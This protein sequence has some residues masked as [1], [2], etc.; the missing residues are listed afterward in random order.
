MADD[1]LLICH[2]Q[3]LCHGHIGW[4]TLKK[5]KPTTN[6][7]VRWQGDACG[8]ICTTFSGS[9]CKKITS[10]QTSEYIL[11][12]CNNNR[13]IVKTAWFM[14]CQRVDHYWPHDWVTLPPWNSGMNNIS[15]KIQVLLS[16]NVQVHKSVDTFENGNKAVLC[17]HNFHTNQATDKGSLNKSKTHGLLYSKFIML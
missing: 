14:C 6:A 15:L 2:D 4:K 8:T 1:L 12:Y 17:K 10:Y 9:W 13:G 7:H 16:E 11:F 5:L 3:E